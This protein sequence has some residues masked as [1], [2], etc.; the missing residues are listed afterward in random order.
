M[1]R[2]VAMLFSTVLMLVFAAGCGNISGGEFTGKWVNSERSA[3]TVEIKKSGEGFIV[4]QSTP[5]TI[6]KIVNNDERKTR[7]YPA[8]LKD[9]VLAVST[10]SETNTISYVK[11]G[12]FLLFEEHKFIRQK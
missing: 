11:D 1:R 9:G 5:T 12:D 8:V 10:G 6:A 7:E 4:T 3:E 2:I